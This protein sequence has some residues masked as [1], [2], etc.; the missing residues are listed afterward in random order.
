MFLLPWLSE[1]APV[2]LQ[3]IRVRQWNNDF[4]SYTSPCHLSNSSSSSNIGSQKPLL[5]SS[6]FPF[7]VVFCHW[8]WIMSGV[9]SIGKVLVNSFPEACAVWSLL[10][11]IIQYRFA[12]ITHSRLK[13]FQ[14]THTKIQV[15][16]NL[17]HNVSYSTP[18][19]KRLKQHRIP[20]S[21]LV[22]PGTLE[23]NKRLTS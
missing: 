6:Y 12:Q 13:C 18:R 22:H 2:Y 19:L 5:Q 8:G 9:L 1:K 11:I 16:L 14:F 10:T 17:C 7:K 4:K 15:A 20:N 3:L 23:L 21:H